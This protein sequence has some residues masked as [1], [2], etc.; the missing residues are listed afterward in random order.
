MIE[1]V[2]SRIAEFLTPEPRY[3][4][5]AGAVFGRAW[6]QEHGMLHSNEEPITT[7]WVLKEAKRLRIKPPFRVVRMKTNSICRKGLCLH[8]KGE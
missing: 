3:A 8:R 7:E 1:K 2:V 6:R 5:F 4:R